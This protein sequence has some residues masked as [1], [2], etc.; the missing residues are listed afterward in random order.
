MA[1]IIKLEKVKKTYLMGDVL[2][3]ALDGVS[4]EIKE[5]EFVAIVGPSGSGKSTLMHVIG[6]L[7]TPSE[8]KIYLKD[9][10]VSRLSD[11]EQAD[12][13]NRHIGFVFQSFNLLAR[14]TSLD[15]VE[16]P[17]IYSGVPLSERKKRAEE[18]LKV[19]GLSDRLY[20]FPSQLS[21]GQQQRV[22]IAR[23]LVNSP[24][25]ILAD[26]PTGN[27]DS[28]SGR[29]ILEILTALNEKGRT[30]VLVTHDLEIA[31]H[32]KRIVEI[33]DGK[34]IKDYKNKQKKYK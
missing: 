20:H 28:K 11:D 16:M 7:D 32:A 26:E 31:A 23:A 21:G 10:D 19:V 3:K 6:L 4:L 14:T 17:L 15:N 13:R 34:I 8:G 33:K 18:E 12:L 29:E 25:M 24:D 9:K 5:G 27:L 2:V 30:I 1:S 22:A